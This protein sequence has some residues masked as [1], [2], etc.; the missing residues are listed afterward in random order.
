[1]TRLILLHLK[2]YSS[3]ILLQKILLYLFQLIIKVILWE[4][5]INNKII[6][7]IKRINNTKLIFQEIIDLVINLYLRCIILFI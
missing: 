7:L 5:K 3:Y 4:N 2:K 6:D 1:M